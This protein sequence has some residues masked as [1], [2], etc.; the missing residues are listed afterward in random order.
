VF[1]LIAPDG[2]RHL[3]E[4]DPRLVTADLMTIREAVLDGLGIAA[5]PEMM[6]GNALRAGQLSPV[7]P[8]WT[9]PVPQLYAVF[10]SRQGMPPAVRAFVDY[11]VEKLDHGEYKQPGCPERAK[12]EAAAAAAAVTA[13]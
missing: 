2:T 12:Q 10:V 11:L 5:L 9:L 6:Y 3:H 13:Q 1:T 4:H 8:G 7:M